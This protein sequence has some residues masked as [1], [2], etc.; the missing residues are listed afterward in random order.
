MQVEIIYR[1]PDGSD[2]LLGIRKL[3]AMPPSGEPF[4]VEDRLFR[5]AGYSGPNNEGCYR[6]FL[7]DDAPEA[8]H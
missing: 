7:V 8:R 6:L 2:T 3:D 1:Q 4:S 5:A